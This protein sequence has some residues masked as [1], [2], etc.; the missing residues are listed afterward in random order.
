MPAENAVELDLRL[1]FLHISCPF[2]LSFYHQLVFV[3]VSLV[4]DGGFLGYS[5]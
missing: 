1:V 2:G 5:L 4:V 3:K